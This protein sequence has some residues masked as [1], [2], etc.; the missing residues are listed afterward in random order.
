MRFEPGPIRIQHRLSSNSNGSWFKS[1]IIHRLQKNNSENNYYCLLCQTSCSRKMVLHQNIWS[2]S[3]SD[4]PQ[5]GQITYF[6]RSNFGTFRLT[7]SICTEIVSEKVKEF[8]NMGL[9]WPTLEPIL[10]TLFWTHPGDVEL[11][12]HEFDNLHQDV[13]TE[14]LP[15]RVT[16]LVQ[17]LVLFVPRLDERGLLCQIELT[18]SVMSFIQLTV[19]CH[20]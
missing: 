10:I 13:D 15:L 19:S 11:K 14:T 16:G 5:M 1:E 6:F 2:R 18:V 12:R 4:F 3:G 17:L 20:L 8:Y 9:I 7:Q